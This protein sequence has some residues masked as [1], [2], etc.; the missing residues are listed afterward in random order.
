[1]MKSGPGTKRPQRSPQ[2]RDFLPPPKPLREEPEEDTDEATDEATPS[3]DGAVTSE[4]AAEMNVT[5]KTSFQRED[6][7]SLRPEPRVP[8]KHALN[9]PIV[10]VFGAGIAGL[11]AAHELVDRGFLVQVIEKAEDTSCPGRPHIGGLAANQAARVRANVEDLHGSLITKSLTEPVKK[12]P[13]YTRERDVASW[14]L[15]MFAFNRSRWIQT[16]KPERINSC[17]FLA[18]ND[19]KGTHFREGLVESLKNARTRY[20]KRWLWDLVGRG[21]LLDAITPIEVV[22][23]DTEVQAETAKRDAYQEATTLVDG[24]TKSDVDESEEDV[25]GTCVNIAVTLTNFLEKGQWLAG[26]QIPSEDDLRKTPNLV[27]PGLQR[28]FLCFRLIPYARR[29]FPNAMQRAIDLYTDW[30]NYFQKVSTLR[31]CCLSTPPKIDPNGIM[32]AADDT[33]VPICEADAEPEFPHLA[34]LEVEVVEQR[35]PGEHGYRFF[36]SFYRHL[37]DTMGRIPL[38]TDGVASGRKVK[39]NL[40]PT[41]FQGIGLGDKD[42]TWIIENSR[43]EKDNP[44]RHYLET[45]DPR[46]T[47]ERYPSYDEPES[48]DCKDPEPQGMIVELE[49]EMPRSI[50]ALRN[51]TDRF[52][53]RVGGTR[54]DA[55]ILLAKLLRYLTSSPERRRRDY[56]TKRWS[57]FVDI[58]KFSTVFRFHIQSAAQSLLAFSAGEAD[59]RTYGNITLQMMLDELRDGTRVDR[60]LNGPTSDAWLEPWRVHL[61]QQGVRFFRG[62][63][64]SLRW[65]EVQKSKDADGRAVTREE[66]VPNIKLSTAKDG[67]SAQGL[68]LLVAKDQEPALQPDFYVLALNIEE[69]A[70]LV[71]RLMKAKR[72]A[73]ALE[74]N[75][76]AAPD[77][78]RL[79]AFKQ[80]VDTVVDGQ[81]ALRNMTGLQYFF[82]AKTAIGRGHLYFPFSKWG[83]SSI[84]QSEFWSARGGFAD[85]YFGLLSVDVCTTGVPPKGTIGSPETG[86]QSFTGR[87]GD[88]RPELCLDVAR[89]ALQQITPRIGSSRAPTAPRCFHVDDNSLRKGPLAPRFLA[90]RVGLDATRPGRRDECV[91]KN[92]IEYHVNFDRWVMC[93]TFM[94]TH[95]RMTTMESANESARHAVAAILEKLEMKNADRPLLAHTPRLNLQIENLVNETYNWAS[96][97]RTYE[98]P[99]T[100]NPEDDEIPDLDFFR[101]IDR[102]LVEADVPHFMDVINFDRKLEHALDGLEIYGEE[103]PLS[104]LLGL[105][106]AS[107]DAALTRELGEKYYGL[108]EA[109]YNEAQGKP[110]SARFTD[111]AGLQNRIKELFDVFSNLIRPERTTTVADAGGTP[112]RIK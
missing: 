66:V 78:E 91:G 103:R 80:A 98:A 110:S 36:P 108:A 65:A 37:D 94:S 63:L 73:A 97:L 22:K 4:V 56:E 48:R 33:P 51:C 104:E 27:V 71:R 6:G 25:S 19:A 39:D 105:T 30:A 38:Y 74:A 62:E 90:S 18:S 79:V 9:P 49:R 89:E 20:R 2:P 60:T 67:Y 59:A 46:Q 50:E 93:G 96:D 35:L 109:W 84:S 7:K 95:T 86:E 54:R 43:N 100:W 26:R 24:L 55:V 34:W 112:L 11:T 1:M 41:V 32:R 57:E 70:S 92:E 3:T 76:N 68:S 75:R 61:E 52:V 29:G 17:I 72:T 10:T 77:F 13:V 23:A 101:R 107:I 15:E 82:D 87:L 58:E 14:L 40:I 85:G 81:T 12:D 69:S 31:D 44:F 64:K 8:G 106:N 45:K 53:R 5:A 42:K 47:D 16:E 111:M 99:P 83:L 102:R 21:V 28:E 88:G